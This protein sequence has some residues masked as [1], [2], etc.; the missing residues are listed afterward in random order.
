MPVRPVTWTDAQVRDILTL[1][2][3]SLEFGAA[4]DRRDWPRVA[5]LFTE[6]ARI[7][8]PE[9]TPEIVGG[10]GL[11]ASMRTAWDALDASQ[12]LHA[13]QQFEVDGD[14][15]SGTF[16]A[17]VTC[18]RESAHGGRLFTYGGAWHDEYRR[19]EAG[20]RVTRRVFRQIWGRGNPELV[21]NRLHSDEMPPAARAQD[22]DGV[23]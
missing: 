8:F 13:N 1:T 7:A 10:G 2:D 20:W 11:V 23:R 6:D 18:V 19:T 16:Y 12:S 22:G 5:G 21:G 4:V 14:R 3:L 17:H 9:G 15:A